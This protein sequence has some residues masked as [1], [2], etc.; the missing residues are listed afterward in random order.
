MG[1]EVDPK[2]PFHQDDSFKAS[3]VTPPLMG[4]W[5]RNWQS[6]IINQGNVSSCLKQGY[7]KRLSLFLQT[8]SCLDRDSWNCYSHLGMDLGW[9]MAVQRWEEP[10]GHNWTVLNFLSV[11]MISLRL[12]WVGFVSH[13]A[14]SKSRGTISGIWA[15]PVPQLDFPSGYPWKQSIQGN[16]QASRM[17]WACH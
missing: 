4:D 8:L 9:S 5:F 15:V 3:F 12:V 11:A 2:H 6:M 17:T 16:L 7:R 10:W 13:S 14:Q 1:R